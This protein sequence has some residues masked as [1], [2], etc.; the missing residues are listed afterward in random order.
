MDNVSTLIY[1]FFTTQTAFT[2]VVG[3][4]IY[5]LVA[6][7]ETPY[8]FVIYTIGNPEPLTKEATSYPVSV[9]LYFEKSSYTECVSFQNTVKNLID[10][11]VNWNLVDSAV[12][13]IEDNQSIVA[14]VNFEIIN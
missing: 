13:F 11:G 12:D 5:P 9:N 1:Q 10:N 4:R 14:T 8:P 2:S 7:E 6:R 3:T